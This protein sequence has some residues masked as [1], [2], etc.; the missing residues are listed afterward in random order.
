MRSAGFK[1]Y[2]AANPD[3]W[4]AFKKFTF[5]LIDK[6]VACYGAKA[7]F[8][9]I[10]FEVTL[11]KG[12]NAFKLNNNFTAKYA[13]K[14]MDLYP[15]HKGFFQVRQSPKTRQAVVTDP[16]AQ[17]SSVSQAGRILSQAAH[18][19]T[20]QPAGQKKFAWGK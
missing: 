7:I 20:K 11:E 10:R 4:T 1:A 2:D 17:V 14:F 15:W 8:E 12:A 9:K 3:I 13:R 5:Q 18:K 6:G 19:K 16:V